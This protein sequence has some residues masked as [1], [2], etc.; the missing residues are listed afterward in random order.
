MQP[1]PE[2]EIIM[3]KDYSQFET[4]ETIVKDFYPE[5]I[6]RWQLTRCLQ[7]SAINS[8]KTASAVFDLESLLSTEF[9]DEYVKA[10]MDDNNNFIPDYAEKEKQMGLMLRK[11]LSNNEKIFVQEKLKLDYAKFKLRQLIMLMGR[12]N[13]WLKKSPT[14]IL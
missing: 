11:R 9:D 4:M 13:I 7:L 6:I 12:K 2:P 10:V 5:A 3:E 8:S 14:V 1:E